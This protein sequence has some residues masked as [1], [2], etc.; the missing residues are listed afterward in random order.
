MWLRQKM[1][2][3]DLKE[4]VGKERGVDI[5][6]GDFFV[7][8]KGDPG[9]KNRTGFFLEALGQIITRMKPN[10]VRKYAIAFPKSY[11]EIAL[12]RVSWEVC[13]TLHLE[14]LLVNE[15]G[16]VEEKTWEDLKKLS[17]YHEVT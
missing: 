10:A 13:K 11:S 14:I 15:N 6:V 1:C 7:E 4:K 8:A 16:E 17:H 3:K 5:R 9:P 12:G 2:G